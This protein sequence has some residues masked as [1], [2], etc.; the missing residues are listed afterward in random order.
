MTI[1]QIWTN[2]KSRKEPED[3]AEE[4]S[5]GQSKCKNSSKNKKEKQKQNKKNLTL[6]GR[7]RT[8]VEKTE[9]KT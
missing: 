2:A 4:T 6:L 9:R 1:G 7:S 8:E 5:L 3:A